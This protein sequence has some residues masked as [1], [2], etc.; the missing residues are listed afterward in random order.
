M[1]FNESLTEHR[2]TLLQYQVDSG[3]YIA[4]IIIV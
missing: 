4:I 3:K 2:V 1:F